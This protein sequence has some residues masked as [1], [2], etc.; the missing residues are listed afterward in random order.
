M[1]RTRRPITTAALMLTL[2]ACTSHA[3]GTTS[4]TSPASRTIRTAMGP[5]TLRNT[6]HRVVVLGTAELDSAVT[7]GVTPVGATSPDAD[8]TPLAYLPEDRTRPIENVGRDKAPDLK[9][10]ASL[11]PDLILGDKHDADRYAAL[12]AIAPTVLT[13]EPGHRWKQNFLVHAAALNKTREARAVEATYAHRATT[14]AAAL[15]DGTTANMVR[16]AEDSKIHIYGRRTYIGTIF[17]D[18]GLTLPVATS[19]DVTPNRIKKADADAIF[20]STHGNPQKAKVTQTTT[21]ATWRGLKAVAENKVFQ[22]DDDVWC[23]GIG[24]TSANQILSDIR[25]DLTE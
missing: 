15:R 5:V 2:A 6:P 8:A 10:I 9:K 23:Q 20:T 17:A 4:P 7:L 14:I 18:V 11:K 3:A 21:S 22:V 25:S 24:Y 16:F 13:A 12:K 1:H 19:L